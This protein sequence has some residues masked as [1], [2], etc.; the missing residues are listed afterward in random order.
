MASYFAHESCYVDNNVNI[1]DDTKIWH[2][3]HILSGSNIGTNCSFGQNC[4]VGPKVN[5]GNGVKV[6]NN[7]SIYEGVEVEDDVF[8]GP[9]MVF[10]NVINPRA[11]IIRKEEFK[12]TLLK[13]GCSIG[14]NATIVCG[15]TIGEYALIGSGTVVNKDVKSYSLMVGVPARQIGWVSKAGN[16]LKF[17][18]NKIAIDSFDNTKYKI[19]NDNLILV[20]E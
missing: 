2:F 16:T 12:K 17:D 5:I 7:I 13:K 3:S 4:V 6:Q 20:E 10:T 14:A 15:V 1:G 9:S 18:E 8:L 11:F 19:Q